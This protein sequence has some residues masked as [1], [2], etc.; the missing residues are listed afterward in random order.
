MDEACLA[1][2]A[3]AEESRRFEADGFLVVPNVLPENLVTQLVETVDRLDAKHRA[4]ADVDLHQ[5]V[6]QIDFI[7]RDE[8]FLQLIDWPLTFPKVWD[9]LGWNVQ[10][11]YTAMTVTPPLLAEDVV[12]ETPLN[13]HQD[14]AEI[15]PDLETDPRPRI[16]L[17][18]AFFL[19]DTRDPG[20]ANFMVMPGSHLTNKLPTDPV[21]GCYPSSEALELSPGT[22]VIFDRRLWHA[23]SPN[24]STKTRKVIF[25]GYSYRWMRP[26]GEMTV[27]H[28]IDSCDPIRRSLLNPQGTWGKNGP[29]E[30]WLVE[31]HVLDAESE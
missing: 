8:I 14:S 11:Y 31:H 10:L 2:R 17:K 22:A 27:E 16:S 26:R 30:D 15:N 20:S 5:R 6:Q 24:R 9:F 23:A 4:D 25:L 18:V 13:W 21:E 29:L 3:T 7:G 12:L 19:T 28:L 1:H